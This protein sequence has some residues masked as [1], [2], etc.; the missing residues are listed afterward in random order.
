MQLLGRELSLAVGF[1]VEPLFPWMIGMGETGVGIEQVG[2]QGAENRTNH[3]DGFLAG[4]Q[5]DEGI[6]A[7]LLEHRHHHC[8]VSSSFRRSS[9]SV[10]FMLFYAMLE[11]RTSACDYPVLSMIELLRF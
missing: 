3:R 4:R 8:H 10:I 2:K 5:R 11:L 1:L 6:A 9:G 7:Y